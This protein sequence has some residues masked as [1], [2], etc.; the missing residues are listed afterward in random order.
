MFICN[1]K[2]DHGETDI[3]GHTNLRTQLDDVH[4][5]ALGDFTT[6]I[7]ETYTKGS[8]KTAIADLLMKTLVVCLSLASILSQQLTRNK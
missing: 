2:T 6:H 7:K 1:A 4:T 5:V 3:T 8:L